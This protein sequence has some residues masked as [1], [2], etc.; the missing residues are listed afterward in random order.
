MLVGFS[1]SSRSASP[2]VTELPSYKLHEEID[3]GISKNFPNVEFLFKH[4]IGKLQ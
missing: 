4:I 2:D 3:L 1:H